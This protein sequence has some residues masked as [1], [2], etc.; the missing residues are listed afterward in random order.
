LET[1]VPIVKYI[2][3]VIAGVEL[4]LIVRALV[5]LAIGKARAAAQPARLAEE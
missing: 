2:F 5:A 3:V 1:F 4:A